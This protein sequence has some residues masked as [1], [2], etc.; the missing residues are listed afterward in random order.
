MTENYRNLCYFNQYEEKTILKTFIAFPCYRPTT[1]QWQALERFVKKF[2][3]ST[4][5]ETE[6]LVVD[7]GSPNFV[8]PHDSL[9]SL[10]QLVRLEK[11]R[12][13]GAALRKAVELTPTGSD[14]FAFL[15]FDLPYSLQDLIG[16]CSAV[17]RGVDVC[18]GVRGEGSACGSSDRLSRQIS[19][20]IFRLFVRSVVVGSISDTQCGI[21]A[22][23]ADLVRLIAR[24]ARIDGFLFDMEWL[25]IA[26][27]HKLCVRQWPV[28]LDAS[29]E[30]GRLS[31]YRL[32]K[33]AG[34]LF[35]LIRNILA[36]RYHDPNL[37]ALSHAHRNHLIEQY[38]R[39]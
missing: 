22:F 6:F 19:H 8:P 12:G 2:Q 39:I 35:S 37:A 36:R 17:H 11:N 29:H 27:H 7:D 30:S 25:Y 18:I 38:S 28:A 20:R 5:G 32:K 34:E 31:S 26:L 14:V 24:K 13:K 10:I 4:K 16:I 21:K 9:T 23:R 3:I 15:D 33:L 1:E